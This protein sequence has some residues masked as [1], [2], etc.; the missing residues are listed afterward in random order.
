MTD[1]MPMTRIDSFTYLDSEGE[2]KTVDLT[3]NPTA[4]C[5]ADAIGIHYAPLAGVT[6]DPIFTLIPWGRVIEFFYRP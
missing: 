5:S 6:N 1:L 3:L 4:K 2:A